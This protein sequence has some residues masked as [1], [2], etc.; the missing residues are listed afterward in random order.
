MRG[1]KLERGVKAKRHKNGHET[2]P[3]CIWKNSKKKLDLN[4]HLYLNTWSVCD[5]CMKV[6]M[7]VLGVTGTIGKLS[8]WLQHRIVCS[9]AAALLS[10]V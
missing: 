2:R 1:C 8:T 3:G 9:I 7:F 4:K 5:S 10:T 6:T